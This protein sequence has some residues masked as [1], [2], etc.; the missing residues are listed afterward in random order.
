[1]Q[2]DS[3]DAIPKKSSLRAVHFICGMSRGGTTWLA[4]TL[5]QHS[6]VAAFG[7]TRFWASGFVEPG[8]NG[9][10]PLGQTK[11]V[12]E[13][14]I[15]TLTAFSVSFSIGPGSLRNV[16]MEDVR[17]LKEGSFRDDDELTP[18]ELF[19]RVCEAIAAR[20]GKG[21]VVEKTPQ[22]INWVDRIRKF[23]PESRFLVMIRDPYGFM[24]SYKHFGDRASP[25]LRKYY[26]RLYHPLGCAI[27][28]RTYLKA[29]L[30]AAERL[31]ERAML[32]NLGE[33]RK[34]EAAVLDRIQEFLGLEPEKLAGSIPVVN[35]SFPD[36]RRPELQPEDYFWMNL[37]CSGELEKFRLRRQ[38][39]GWA[40][41]R[42]FYSMLRLPF[43][44][45][46]NLWDLRRRVSGSILSYVLRWLW[47]TRV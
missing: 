23:F 27:V 3:A 17:P 39:A 2:S 26:G 37:L 36:D 19:S 10:Y 47:P 8:P 35:T 41:H 24:L 18:G 46:W 16:Q 13:K 31:P 32:V 14:L 38:P 9:K 25:E 33:V 7:E 34:D 42:V 6:Q 1:M 20:E 43:W 40:V 21:V 44:G 28:W 30:L 29:S 12:V 22:N 11:E 4:R 5:N 15:R 45:L